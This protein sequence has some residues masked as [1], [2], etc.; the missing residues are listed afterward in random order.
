M[1]VF[2]TKQGDRVLSYRVDDQHPIELC[3]IGYRTGRRYYMPENLQAMRAAAKLGLVGR[4]LNPGV[5]A[6]SEADVVLDVSGGDSFTDMYPDDRINYMCGSKELVIS[7]GRPLVLLPQTY[8]PFDKS[9]DRARKIVRAAYSCYARDER[10]YETLKSMLGEEFDPDRHKCGVDMAFGLVSRDPGSK[11]DSSLRSWIEEPDGV[12][13]GFNASG[14]IGNTP[15]LD[16]SKYGFRS[17]YRSTLEQALR[18]LLGETDARVILVPHVMA[19]SGSESDWVLSDWLM[20]QL[21][22]E[23]PGR[24]AISPSELDQCEVK[25]LI[26]RVNWFC[27][28][29][30]H[31]TI[32]SL[33]SGVP[34]ATISYSD[35][36]VGVFETCGQGNEVF[37]PRVLDSTEIVEGVID[38]FRRRKEIRIDLGS[39][40]VGVKEQAALQMDEIAAMVEDLGTRRRPE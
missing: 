34:T 23:F 30:M 13:I 32:A 31:S 21:E 25:W 35:K 24:V 10:S 14:L 2:D 20:K 36:A 28:T 11:L 8:G 40:I 22:E 6:I 33:S 3:V 19:K 12:T 27:G 1:S 7:S 29:R 4:F 15:G 5:K 37:D 16:R 39:R 17:D 26:S 38:S 18:A 9:M